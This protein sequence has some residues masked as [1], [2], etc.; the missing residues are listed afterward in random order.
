MREPRLPCDPPEALEP[1][2]SLLILDL[3]LANMMF[4][5]NIAASDHYMEKQEIY[6][7]D[8]WIFNWEAVS[9]YDRAA[10]ICMSY[11]KTDFEFE[12]PPSI[13]MFNLQFTRDEYL[14]NRILIGP[15]TGQLRGGN[16]ATSG[17]QL[18]YLLNE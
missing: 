6:V 15:I 4:F 5:E 2:E 11:L 8:D 9:D 14:G 17:Q 7:F 3:F 12:T 16:E 1:R 10:S 13:D 18:K